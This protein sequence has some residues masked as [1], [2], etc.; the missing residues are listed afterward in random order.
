M[1]SAQSML[2]DRTWYMLASSEM[3][4]MGSALI[5]ASLANS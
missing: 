2:Q 3:D 5:S 1:L 4:F